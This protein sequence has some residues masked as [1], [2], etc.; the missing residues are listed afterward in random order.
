[1]KRSP[2]DILDRFS[3]ATLK[4]ERIGLPDSRKEYELFKNGYI[5]LLA[6]HESEHSY[7]QGIFEQLL[8]V[9]GQIW[10]LESEIRQGQ[11]D[12]DIMRVGERAISIR[13]INKF[14]TIL[15]PME[16]FQIWIK[17]LRMDTLYTKIIKK[18]M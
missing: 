12:N 16:L 17:C 11:L 7:I 18:D 6:E 9:N 3:I 2:G 13:K 5:E 8:E 1:M 14:I 4:L 15:F 10:H